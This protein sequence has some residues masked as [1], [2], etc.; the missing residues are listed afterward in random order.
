[1]FGPLAKPITPTRSACKKLDTNVWIE[2]AGIGSASFAQTG[3]T[4]SYGDEVDAQLDAFRGADAQQVMRNLRKLFAAC[5][6]FKTTTGGIPATV[7]VVAKAGP[8]VGDDSVA[9]V[10][11]SPVWAGGATLVAVRVGKAVASVLYSSSKSDL[12]AKATNLAATMAKRL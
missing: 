1:V 6:R 7:R 4:D 8:P 11:T 5:A 12:G 3:F 2:G 9:A 10:L